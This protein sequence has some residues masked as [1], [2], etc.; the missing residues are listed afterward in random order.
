[1]LFLEIVVTESDSFMIQ[2]RSHPSITNSGPGRRISLF[3]QYFS[4]AVK[5]E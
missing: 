2:Y 4:G 3:F 5:S 1:M